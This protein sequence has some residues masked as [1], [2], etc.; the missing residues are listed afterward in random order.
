MKWLQSLGMFLGRLA[1]GALFI[2]SAFGK[3]TQWDGTVQ[4]MAAK[5]MT[6][7]PL[8]LLLSIL[9]ELLGGLSLVFGYKCRW[10]ATVLLLYLIPVTGIFHDFWNVDEADK[11]LQIIMFMKN[12]AIFGGLL[13]VACCGSGKCGVDQCCKT[14]PHKI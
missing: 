12:L 11:Q 10:A 5:G 7:I 8:F 13:Y 6:M 1:I 3:I 9:V 2:L 4:F 14:E